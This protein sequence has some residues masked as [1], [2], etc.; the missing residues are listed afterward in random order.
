MTCSRL[1]TRW[2]SLLRRLIRDTGIGPSG[3]PAIAESRARSGPRTGRAWYVRKYGVSTTS[4]FFAG[5]AEKLPALCA[6]LAL[7]AGAEAADAASLWWDK[8]RVHT[9]SVR[10]C[11]AIAHEAMQGLN[12]RNIRL[13]R[14]EVAGSA[15][16]V[17]AAVTCVGTN[18]ATAVVMV[19]GDQ[20]DATRTASETLS[21]KIG[22][23][24]HP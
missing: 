12:Y 1:R 21:K 19:A 13:S 9:A 11:L 14:D 15:P 20:V 5:K 10:E 2:R 7:L 4:S 18:P 16:G 23:T 24:I 8:T 17:Y 3:V 22:G 6:G